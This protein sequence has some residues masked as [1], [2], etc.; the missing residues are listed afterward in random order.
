VKRPGILLSIFVCIICIAGCSGQQK[1]EQ[2]KTAIQTEHTTPSESEK[3]TDFT[4]DFSFAGDVLIAS[5][6]NQT[7]PGSFNEYAENEPP[8]YFFRNFSD[9]FRNDD[10]TIVNLENVLT[11]RVLTPV[12]KGTGT[13]FWFCSKTS[14]TDIL[15]AASIDVVSLSN[16]HYGDYGI[17]GQEDTK[18]ALDRAGIPWGYDDKTVYLEKNGYTVALICNVLWGEWQAENII[19]RIDEAE[20][21]SDFQIVF[22]HGGLE[23]LHKP[24]AWKVNACRKLVDH[25]ADL[26]IGHHPH[27]LQP[28]EVYNGVDIVQ[29]LGNFCFGGN[30][31]PENRTVLMQYTLNLTKDN[32]NGEITLKDKELNFIPC[33]VYTG[34]ANNYQPAKITNQGEVQ[35]VLD[36][37]SGTRD[38]PY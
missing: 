20:K 29:S 36:F 33:Y 2:N 16:N 22:Y 21:Q 8:E 28:A 25:G 27:V 19:K 9:I 32:Q 14:N 11:D 7:I 1:T 10:Y 18:D 4:I 15:K 26:V 37:M 17:Q 3:Y 6:L 5:Q 24:E 35:K 13:S 38:L 23:R 31:H 30:T 12:Y 34:T